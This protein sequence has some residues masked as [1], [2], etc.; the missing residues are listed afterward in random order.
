ML[1]LSLPCEGCKRS[2]FFLHFSGTELN[3]YFEPWIHWRVESNAF[4]WSPQRD[5]TLHWAQSGEGCG[6]RPG[7]GRS[8]V[9]TGLWGDDPYDSQWSKK[10]GPNTSTSLSDVK[11]K[12]FA[13]F[14]VFAPLLA[15]FCWYR[16]LVV[17]HTCGPPGR[18]NVGCLQTHRG[19]QGVPS[20]HTNVSFCLAL[21]GL[22]G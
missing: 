14:A 18:L 6:S 7:R 13:V 17:S 21:W 19:T 4:G 16:A 8:D 9:L 11:P 22:W 1:F 20:V 3:V 10:K 5:R 15:A 12:D 2:D